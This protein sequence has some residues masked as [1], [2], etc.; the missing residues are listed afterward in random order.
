MWVG[1]AKRSSLRPS[2]HQGPQELHGSPARGAHPPPGSGERSTHRPGA[3]T[4]TSWPT[5]GP[6][7]G[8]GPATNRSCAIGSDAPPGGAGPGSGD[9]SGAADLH[10][11][12]IAALVV[13]LV[14][15]LPAAGCSGGASSGGGAAAWGLGD[16]VTFGA[17]LSPPSLIPALGDP[18]YGSFYQLAYDPLVVMGRTAATAPALAVKWVTS[19]RGIAPMS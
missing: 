14:A 9:R 7:A 12:R 13:A 18:A 16:K 8:G 11:R 19:E 2:S 5:V 4:G 1:T 3:E 15:V 17:P 6:H 10:P